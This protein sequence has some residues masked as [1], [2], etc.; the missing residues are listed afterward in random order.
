MITSLAVFFTDMRVITLMNAGVGLLAGAYLVLLKVRPAC[1]T[2]HKVEQPF[3]RGETTKESDGTPI[4]SLQQ[5]M[6][7]S[8]QPEELKPA[9]RSVDSQVQMKPPASEVRQVYRP[10]SRGDAGRVTRDQGNI[11]QLIT[12]LQQKARFVDFL[13]EDVTRYTDEQVG[14][15]ARVLHE[16]CR[17]VFDDF[18]RV[19]AVHD[20]EEGS[21]IELPTGYA[22][23]DYQVIGDLLGDPP[24][25]VRLIHKGW[26]V[27]EVSLPRLAR[28]VSGDWPP[29]FRA[30]VEIP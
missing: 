11:L 16:G 26:R 22:A 27:M 28:S 24:Y 17:S 12:L 29:I 21:L 9:V 8:T 2:K 30:Q 7:K 1:K 23:S 4:G 19:E 3:P 6:A 14:A 13:S 10:A 5:P 15:A 18:V 25:C 20:A